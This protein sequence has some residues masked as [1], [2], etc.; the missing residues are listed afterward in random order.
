MR[1][2]LLKD[3]NYPKFVLLISGPYLIREDPYCRYLDD[4]G[5]VEFGD[6]DTYGHVFQKVLVRS[7]A[8]LS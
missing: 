4:F 2:V 6:A 7:C 8:M 5:P 3:C 1:E